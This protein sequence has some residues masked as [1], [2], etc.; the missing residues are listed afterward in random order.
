MAAQ[1]DLLIHNIGHLVTM[2][3][4]REVLTDA[5]LL[6]R[7]GFIAA[8][9]TGNPPRA[10]GTPRHDARG[11]IATPGLINTHHHF[12]QTMARAYTPGN[13]LPLLPWLAHMNR[14]WRTF[15]ADDL[16]LCTSLALAEMML[17][18]C[19][20]AA[21]HHYVV[22]EG[23]GD[24]FDAQFRAAEEMGVRFHMG[25]GSMDIASDLIGAWAVQTT[26]AIMQDCEPAAAKLPW[27][28]RR[29]AGVRCSLRRA[30]PRPRAAGCW[31]NRQGMPANTISGLHSHCGETVD[32]DKY[33]QE[34]FGMRQWNTSRIA[35]G[36]LR[37]CGSRTASHFTDEEIRWLGTRRIGVAHC[38]YANMRLGS[39]I[40]R[41][42]RPACRRGEGRHRRGWQRVK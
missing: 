42:E 38:P 35:A 6:A 4:A 9:G 34:H 27:T 25:R 10:E 14:L 3:D 26:D 22:P 18:G 5:W 20:N 29:V 2:N 31:S 19:T 23:S 11:G 16:A 15:T 7:D 36:I 8:L 39:G 13:N 30:P 41:G 33:S 37:A 12:Y 1:G 17:T 24:C 21:D 40:C 28:P 32:E